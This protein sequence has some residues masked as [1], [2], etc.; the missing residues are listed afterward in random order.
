[1]SERQRVVDHV[2]VPGRVAVAGEQDRRWCG[3][4]VDRAAR[5]A[6]EQQEGNVMTEVRLVTDRKYGP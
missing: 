5:T 6:A 4:V 2:G 1:M 3:N